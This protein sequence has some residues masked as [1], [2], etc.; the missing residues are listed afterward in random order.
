[1][2]RSHGLTP[3]ELRVTAASGSFRKNEPA[4]KP[5]PLADHPARIAPSSVRQR[6][7]PPTMKKYT[8]EELCNMT[9]SELRLMRSKLLKQYQGLG[10]FISSS[11]AA[12]MPVVYMKRVSEDSSLY[13]VHTA[14]SAMDLPGFKSH[15]DDDYGENLAYATLKN[16][17]M[18]NDEL[19]ELA[20]KL[21]E[22]IAPYKKQLPDSDEYAYEMLFV[23]VRQWMDVVSAWD[24]QE[25]SNDPGRVYEFRRKVAAKLARAQ[26]EDDYD[27]SDDEPEPDVSQPINPAAAAAEK[28]KKQEMKKIAEFMKERMVRQGE[29]APPLPKDGILAMYR[30]WGRG[31]TLQSGTLITEYMRTAFSAR[32]VYISDSDK[33]LAFQGFA[34]KDRRLDLHGAQQQRGERLPPRGVRL[35]S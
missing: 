26:K 15:D 8:K 30:I 4:P 31:I 5:S 7:D 2:R 34:L 23:K 22:T 20:E 32:P 33:V 10:S 19:S 27:T 24:E 12:I 16:T 3:I 17:F 29:S 9:Q 14:R 13:T 21:K 11:R 28:A 1:M 35:L 6:K 25:Q 18:T